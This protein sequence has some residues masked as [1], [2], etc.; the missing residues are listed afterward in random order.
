MGQAKQRG[1]FAQ[2]QAEGIAKN[3]A[4]EQARR[5]AIAEAEAALTPAQRKK[6]LQAGMI[7]TSVLGMAAASMQRR[8]DFARAVGELSGPNTN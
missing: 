6:R 4:Q 8:V 3:E 7:L 5:K 2:R 1:T